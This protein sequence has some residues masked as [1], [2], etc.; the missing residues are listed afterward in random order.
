MNKFL[1]A[2]IVCVFS[3]SALACDGSHGKTKTQDASDTTKSKTKE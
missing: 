2:M 3:V 1:L